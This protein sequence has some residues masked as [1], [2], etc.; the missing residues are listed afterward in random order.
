MSGA[1][2][3]LFV[4]TLARFL[5]GKR[6]PLIGTNAPAPASAALLAKEM[7]GGNMRVTILGSRLHSF[8]SDDLAEVFD[9]ATRGN[10]DAFFVGGGQIDGQA[11]INLVG[12]GKHPRLDVRWPGSHGTP[13]L[14]LM[15]PNAILYREEH[16]SR[17]FVERVDFISAPGVSEPGVHRPGGPIALVTSRCVFD[18]LRDKGAFRLRSLHPG[19]TLKEVSD[20]TGFSYETPEKVGTTPE[21]TTEM[22]ML[23]KD[24]VAPQIEHLYPQYA[25][26]LV[27]ETGNALKT[28][29]FEPEPQRTGTR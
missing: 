14:Y 19:A 11:N 17:A 22:L 26:M 2:T 16:T 9:A 21:P 27:R 18:F 25:A 10:F 29:N 20:N 6:H 8:L 4:T 3:L 7:A 23:L 12:I 24:R 13:L 15:I 1:Q 5:E 28:S